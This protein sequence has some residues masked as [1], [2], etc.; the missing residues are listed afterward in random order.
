MTAEPPLTLWEQ[1]RE[2]ALWQN[3]QLYLPVKAGEN[4]KPQVWKLNYA[5]KPQRNCTFMNSASG[6]SVL[7]PWC[8]GWQ[9][10]CPQDTACLASSRRSRS[11]TKVFVNALLHIPPP[12]PGIMWDYSLVIMP[13]QQFMVPEYTSSPPLLLGYVVSFY[14]LWTIILSPVS[15][16]LSTSNSLSNSSNFL[17]YRYFLYD[18]PLFIY[19]YLD[20]AQMKQYP[21]L[22]KIKIIFVNILFIRFGTDHFFSFLPFLQSKLNLK[23]RGSTALCRKLW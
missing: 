12:P 8:T 20:K 11:L 9:P 10:W 19:L 21:Y 17:W 18:W 15:R 7:G 6:H 3:G 1:A 23:G 4:W 22:L 2:K 5:Q 16:L 14:F 13:T